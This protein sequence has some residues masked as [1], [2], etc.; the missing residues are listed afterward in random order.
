MSTLLIGYDL[1]SPGK[2]YADLITRIKNHG[3]WWHH[4]DSTWLIVTDLTAKQ[5]RD[6]LS[7]YVD[8][9]DELL[10]IDVSDDSWAGTGFQPRAYDWL[11]NNL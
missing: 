1:N 5:M 11:T 9:N 7:A 3:A 4:L 6:D 2:D 8:S 10:V